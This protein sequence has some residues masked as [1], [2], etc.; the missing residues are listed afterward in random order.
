MNDDN[1][2]MQRCLE[3]ARNGLG[4]VAPNPLVGCVIVHNGLIIGEG[5]HHE[6]GGPHAEINALNAV[7][8]RDLLPESTLYVNLEPCCHHG[9]T[10]PCTDRV[11]AEGIRKVVIGMTDPFADVSGKGI[12]QLKA[13]GI[14]VIS[15]IMEDE[16]RRLN[17]RFITFHEKHRPYVILKWARTLDGFIDKERDTDEPQINWITD[18]KTRIL[19]HKWRAEEKAVMI[20]GNTARKDNPRLTVRDWTGKNPLRVVIDDRGDLD[21]DLHVFN[22]EADT[23]YFAP[24]ERKMGKRSQ[25]IVTDF[26]KAALPFIMKTLHERN[27]QSI[28]IEGGKQLLTS[29]IEAGLWDEA[30][31]FT[32]NLYFFKGVE[33]PKISGGQYTIEQIGKDILTTIIN[34]I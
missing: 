7:T 27:I 3:M 14:E 9:K 25:T 13:A 19:V 32:G 10:P 21:K 6:F 29:V 2:Y 17:H 5:Y 15:G 16:C 34:K 31:I 26:N 18:E 24:A 11:I 22:E 4:L 20:G 30:R 33:S 8:A 28:I 1:L 23:L 12:E